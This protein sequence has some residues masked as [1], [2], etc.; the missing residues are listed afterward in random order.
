MDYRVGAGP[1]AVRSCADAVGGVADPAG[2]SG[3]LG[4]DGR[5][6]VFELHNLRRIGLHLVHLEVGVE[7]PYLIASIGNRLTL[8][9]IYRDQF[10]NE[11]FRANPAQAMQEN[12]ELSGPVADDRQFRIESLFQKTAQ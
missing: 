7:A 4:K 5:E 10:V 3:L 11:S 12:R 8:Q 1:E 2:R 6:T 9:I